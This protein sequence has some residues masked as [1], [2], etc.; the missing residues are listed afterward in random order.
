MKK[1]DLIVIG[2][3]ASGLIASIQAAKNNKEVL[4]LEKLPQIGAKLKA[5]GGGRCNLTNTLSNEDFMKKFG[6]NG[7][8]MQDALRA[9]NS[10]DLTSFFKS[11]G[12]DT[13]SLDGFRVF[14]VT[15]SSS[16]IISALENELDT[17]K[18][19]CKL[20]QRVTNIIIENDICK[21]V[22]VLDTKYF[23]SNIIIATGGLGYPKLGAEGD[24]HKISEKIGHK[25]TDLYPAMMPLITKEKWVNCTADTMPKV[26]IQ[27]DIP[28]YKKLKATGDLIFTKN[29]IRGL[30]VLDFSK[31]ITPLIEKYTEVPILINF[32]KGKNE[33]EVRSLI[34]KEIALNKEFSIIDILNRF[35]PRPFSLEILNLCNINEENRFNQIEGI[36]RDKL[37]KV[38]TWTPFTVIGHNGFQNAMITRGGIS[39]KEINPK[40]M[41]SKLVKSLYFCGEIID[42]DGP[43][44]GY[45]L[46][47][48][49][50]SGYLA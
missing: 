46:Q 21:G 5:T 6:R 40:T 33:E 28:K 15:H 16:T 36:K 23:A 35:L 17:L 22:E 4:L 30:V 48:A 26:T 38:L 12:V 31:E 2:S 42:L 39:L 11:I 34:K 24:G 32:L 20:N 10:D 25:V 37:I 49:F 3:G 50:S 18:V 41:E 7:R 43:C 27:V 13:H 45:N 9:F 29:G 44:G 8:F 19:E 1:Y 14:P 47:W